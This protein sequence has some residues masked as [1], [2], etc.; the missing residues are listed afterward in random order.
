MNEERIATSA[1]CS[2]QSGGEAANAQTQ[3]SSRTRLKNHPHL[4]A[5]GRATSRLLLL[6]LV[7]IATLAGAVPR[8]A[9]EDRVSFREDFQAQV[10][11]YNDNG[12]GTSE[13]EFYGTGTTDPGGAAWTVIYV[14][15]GNSYF[16]PGSSSWLTPLSGTKLVTTQNGD[17]L[18]TTFTGVDGPSGFQVT[19]K[20]AGG[21][22]GLQGATGTLQ[23]SG[24]GD[25]QGNIAF[26]S[27]GTIRFDELEDE[28]G[29][30]V[31][32][33][34]DRAVGPPEVKVEGAPNGYDINTGPLVNN[35][36]VEDGALITLF[37]VDTYG[38]ILDW[39]GR[40]VDPSLAAAGAFLDALDIVWVQHDY[41]GPLFGGDLQVGFN[42]AFPGVYYSN[43]EIHGEDN[44]GPVSSKWK[45]V[46]SSSTVVIRFK[47]PGN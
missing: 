39:G 40:F 23:T 22:G 36:A 30:I 8:A 10:F 41:S 2:R 46:Y 5:L 11:M 3:I 32:S 12:D 15:S 31:V 27:S 13:Q 35:P 43:P 25:G 14:H 26:T 33:I 24:Q 1:A 42:S 34:N 20:I 44:L 38:S 45:T 19:Q 29:R 17:R 9:A 18:Y 28:E 37:G 16:D 21:T 4:G 7:G 47:G 6:S